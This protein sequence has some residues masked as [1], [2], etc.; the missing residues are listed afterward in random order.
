MAGVLNLAL[1]VLYH[2]IFVGTMFVNVPL[3]V[4][5][6]WN[7]HARKHILSTVMLSLAICD[8]CLGAIVCSMAVIWT[9]QIPSNN[10]MLSVLG[11]VA[12]VIRN[13]SLWHLAAMSAFKCYII[14][15]PLTCFAVS[16]IRR[17]LLVIGALW[18]GCVMVIAGAH[19]GGL[20][21]MID[22]VYRMGGADGQPS[23]RKQS[24]YDR[25][26]FFD[27]GVEFHHYSLL[28]EDPARS[29]SQHALTAAIGGAVTGADGQPTGRDRHYWIATVRLA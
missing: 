12:F 10:L 21:W 18:I 29:S 3:F 16:T 7:R 19:I 1:G 22:P 9:A 13:C 23:G 28:R 26:V 2:F 24:A 6:T 17:R 4:F 11:D 5:L 27:A 15:K 20:K 8:L 14:V 25:M